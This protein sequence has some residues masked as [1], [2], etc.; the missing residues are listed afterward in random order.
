MLLLP[1]S[2]RSNDSIIP[3]ISIEESTV[4]YYQTNTCDFSLQEI[5]SKN[6]NNNKIE[7]LPDK[8]STVKCFGKINGVD[9]FSDSIKVY[10]GTNM[11]VDF[12]LQSLFILL[13]VS[14]IPTSGNSKK[15]K[16]FFAS[17]TFFCGLLYLHLKGEQIYYEYFSKNFNL[18]FSVDNYFLLSL[19]LICMLTIAIFNDLMKDKF[20]NFL[21][22]LPFMFLFVG[23]F[24][25]L[26]I[27]IFVLFLAFIGFNS[28]LENKFNKRYFF[29][30]LVF[31]VIQIFNFK[32]SSL[33]FDVDKLKG[34]V[35]S[36]QTI[37]S[38]IYWI[39][40]FYFLI[41]GILYLINESKEFF[42]LD[43]FIRNLLISGSTITAIGFLSAI[44]P[45]LNFITYYY[46]GLNKAGIKNLNSIEGNTWRGIGS[47][48]EALGEF[49]GFVILIT[50]LGILAK[51]IKFNKVTMLLLVINFYGL[52]ETNNFAALLSLLILIS[53]YILINFKMLNRL[54]I[55]TITLIF[56]IFI[57]LFAST[58]SYELYSRALLRE[59]YIASDL[60]IELPKD[61]DNNTAVDNLNFGEILL[62]PKDQTNISNSLYLFTERF[63][64]VKNIK[65]IPNEIAL[66]S[67]VAKT[68]NRSEKWGV[69]LAKY[70]PN[71]GNFLF[72][73]GPNQLSEYY[74]GHK[75]K[76][77]TGLVLPHSSY[78]DFLIFYGLFGLL[79][80]T[81]IISR[82]LYSN[83]KNY[84]YL[85]LSIYL[86][87]N[88]IKSDSILYVASFTLFIFIINF[89]KIENESIKSNE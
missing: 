42:N 8:N 5:L 39:I 87:I 71:L 37:E 51:K 33:L 9:Y 74:L 17:V 58:I 15:I 7:I 30:Y 46:L 35:N 62:Y 12:L 43:L 78:L 18:S 52:Y 81:F 50:S 72:G 55:L 64:K 6:F 21:N 60:N 84:F 13:L 49:Y 68:I 75:T 47:S 20:S 59:G 56:A 85:I 44:N 23:T 45:F 69:F 53:F 86:L 34:F 63:T 22:Y 79:F 14:T 3:A 80:I 61:Q 67:F 4:G 38:L 48:A 82:I 70:N 41:C 83:R 11:N 27:N 25:T 26:N 10:V 88:L 89:Y 31:S 76:A 1:W 77:N 32:E 16:M 24:N 19:F 36:S 40:I 29:V 65:Y 2:I 57:S 28:F 54:S 73:Y 66:V